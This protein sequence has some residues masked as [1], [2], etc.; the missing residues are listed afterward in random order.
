MVFKFQPGEFFIIPNRSILRGQGPMLRSVYMA[1]CDHANKDGVCYPSL[2]TIG[3]ESGISRRSVIRIIKQLEE[4]GLIT[5]LERF[6]NGNG[7]KNNE[8]QLNIVKKSQRGSV[9]GTL[10]IVSADNYLVS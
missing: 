7:W 9:Q 5:K 6:E 8:Y 2:S 1:L 10:G 4:L 3:E